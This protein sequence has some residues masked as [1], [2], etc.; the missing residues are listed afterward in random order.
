[1]VLKKLHSNILRDEYDPNEPL[2]KVKTR[3]KSRK[4]DKFA[5]VPKLRTKTAIESSGAYETVLPP[6]LHESQ[7]KARE[8]DRERFLHI[9]EHGETPEIS[10]VKNNQKIAQKLKLEADRKI[11]LSNLSDDDPE[12]RFKEVTRE[13][14]ERRE[15]LI[16]LQNL[17]SIDKHKIQIIQTEISRVRFNYEKLI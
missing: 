1:M 14:E 2:V 5:S 9:L 16:E 4:F 3:P 11:A 8:T 15:F 13:I 12:A 17:K 7:L 10:Q 6:S